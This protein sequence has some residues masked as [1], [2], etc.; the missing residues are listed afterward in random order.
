MKK[1]IL[2][3]STVSITFW[4][5]SQTV[6]VDENFESY[7]ANQL[8]AQQSATWETWSSPTGGGSDDALISAAV[9]LS[10]NNSMLITHDKD[11]ILPIGNFSSGHF[12]V[13]YNAYMVEEAYF[14]IMHTCKTSWA[15]DLYLTASNTIKYLDQPNIVNSIVIDTFSNNAWVNFR[16]DIDIDADIITTYIND[17]QRHQSTFSNAATGSSGNGLSCL[18]FFGL[19]LFNG[20]DNSNYYIDDIL[21]TQLDNTSDVESVQ[22]TTISL[23]PNPSSEILTATS[24]ETIKRIRIYNTLG[25]LILELNDVTEIN[26]SEFPNGVYH[27]EFETET[28]YSFQK[29]FIVQHQ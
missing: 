23:S 22:A 20:V 2:I 1:V 4:T 7:T 27:A 11:M 9:S 29:Q 18:N 16:F 17:V 25:K 13:E 8:L 14:N 6:V 10:G 26:V 21:I 24:E 5:L 19:D 28:N 15:V 12:M 3:I